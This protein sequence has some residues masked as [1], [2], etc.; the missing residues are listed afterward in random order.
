MAK[1]SVD[2]FADELDRLVQRFRFEYSLSYAEAVGCLMMR[3]HT[4]MVEADELAQEE[5]EDA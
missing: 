5:G 1:S 3:A 4:L 2:H